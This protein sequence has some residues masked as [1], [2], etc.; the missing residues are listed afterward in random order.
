MGGTKFAEIL[1]MSSA[2]FNVRGW[3]YFD[4]RKCSWIAVALSSPMR[5][6]LSTE[7]ILRIETCPLRGKNFSREAYR[8]FSSLPLCQAADYYGLA[9]SITSG[10]GQR[11][12]NRHAGEGEVS[13][14]KIC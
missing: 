11:Y 5:E 8:V 1:L 13:I 2:N 12:V 10:L 4:E 6:L 14:F 9:G 3:T 7:T